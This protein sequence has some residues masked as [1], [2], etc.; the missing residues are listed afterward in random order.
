MDRV[1]LQTGG[2]LLV[3][4][5]RVGGGVARLVLA[6]HEILRRAPEE[7]QGANDP[8]QLAEFPMAP[9]VN[10]IA[11]GRL[12][13]EGREIGVADGP[14][15]HPQG[16]HGIS[17]RTSWS[18]LHQND[19]EVVLEMTWDGSAGWPFRFKLT[20]R[21]LLAHDELV[22]EATLK[23]LGSGSMPA[24]LGFHPYFSSAGARLRANTS[25]AWTTSSAGLPETLSHEDVA[26]RMASGLAVEEEPL[27]HCFVEWD[28]S[29]VIAWPNHSITMRTDPALRY[30]QVYSPKAADHF[31]VEPQSAMPDCFN[32]PPSIGGYEVL[33]RGGDLA[34]SLRLQVTSGT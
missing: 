22:I 10:R 20:R 15:G 27:D 30:L 9:W 6:G 4:A 19:A 18:V 1:Q 21:F 7:G 2:A 32:R 13:W 25:A 26:A 5:P 23:N 28:G 31:C 11:N 33:E 14:G 12:I 24:A 3:L 29:A 8:L 34:V 16:L 17:W